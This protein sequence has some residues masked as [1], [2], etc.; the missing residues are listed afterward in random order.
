MRGVRFAVALVVI[1]GWVG[2]GNMSFVRAGGEGV[3]RL[4]AAGSLRPALTEVIAA[5]EKAQGVKVE[6]T[7]GASGL[8]REQR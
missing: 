3:V 5:F 6:P 8:L 4:Y 2:L 7:F 1:I